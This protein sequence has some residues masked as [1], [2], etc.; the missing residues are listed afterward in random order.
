MDGYSLAFYTLVAIFAYL[1]IRQLSAN[2]QV[3][4]KAQ[5]IELRNRSLGIG[6]ELQAQLNTLPRVIQELHQMKLKMQAQGATEQMLKP[7]QQQIWLAEQ[8][9]KWSPVLR[10]AAPILNRVSTKVVDKGLKA[11]ENLI[12]G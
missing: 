7:I 1:V 12:T 4:V 9:Q 8:A 11:L 3:K 10:F 2:W 6:T 5:S